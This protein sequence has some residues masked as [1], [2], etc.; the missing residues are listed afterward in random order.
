MI[1]AKRRD[2][3]RLRVVKS[4]GPFLV[5]PDENS[6]ARRA[7]N[8]LGWSPSSCCMA[9]DVVVSALRQVSVWCSKLSSCSSLGQCQYRFL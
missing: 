7:G 5:S 1:E 4:A 2:R 6:S 8:S 9:V 3:I